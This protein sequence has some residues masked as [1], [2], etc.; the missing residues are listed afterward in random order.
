MDSQPA[1]IPVIP[2]GQSCASPQ[3]PFLQAVAT[4]STASKTAWGFNAWLTVD[5]LQQPDQWKQW[6]VCNITRGS[7]GLFFTWDM[8]LPGPRGGLTGPR[9]P[10][11]HGSVS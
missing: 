3:P 10:S 6:Q 5:A 8:S 7:L 9:V 1:G 11:P 4:I 2:S